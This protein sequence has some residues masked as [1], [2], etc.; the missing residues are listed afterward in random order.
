MN[1]YESTIE[2]WDERF[3][4]SLSTNKRYDYQKPIQIIEIE[5]DLKMDNQRS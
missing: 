2:F 5:E 3:G 1:K 4:K